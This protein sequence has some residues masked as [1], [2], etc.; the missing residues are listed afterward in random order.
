MKITGLVDEDFINYKAPSMFISTSKCSFK[1]DKQ[2]GK[3][4]CQNSALAA[5][6]IIDIDDSELCQRY[7]DNPIT[8]AIVIGGLEPFDTPMELKSFIRTAS[9]DFEIKDPI[10]IYTGYNRDEINFSTYDYLFN[11]NK[12]IIIKFGR[13]VPNMEKRYDNLL[14]VELASK[15]QYAMTIKDIM[16]EVLNAAK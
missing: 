1:C 14:G 15:N 13:Y 2:C 5:A 8:E 7:I 6:P 11:I 4:I 3:P 16:M 12:N 10:I 9:I